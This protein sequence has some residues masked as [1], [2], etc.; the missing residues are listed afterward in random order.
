MNDVQQV[1]EQMRNRP[2][3]TF[4]ELSKEETTPTITEGFTDEQ[5]AE[6]DAEKL[7]SER[8]AISGQEQQLQQLLADAAGR[9]QRIDAIL[10]RKSEL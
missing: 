2:D 4:I 5:I 8:A 6:M 9:R 1:L 3:V 7:R 10:R